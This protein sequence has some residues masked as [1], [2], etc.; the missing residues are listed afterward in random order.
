M[1]K[2]TSTSIDHYGKEYVLLVCRFCCLDHRPCTSDACWATGRMMKT[3]GRLAKKQSRKSGAYRTVGPSRKQREKLC[4]TL[5]VLGD[6]GTERNSGPPPP[7]KALSTTCCNAASNAA[8]GKRLHAA[9]WEARPNIFFILIIHLS[10]PHCYYCIPFPFFHNVQ[11]HPATHAPRAGYNREA[12]VR[13]RRRAEG[14]AA[15]ATRGE[16]LLL[17][18]FNYDS[19]ITGHHSPP[20]FC[21]FSLLVFKVRL[22]ASSS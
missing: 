22:L 7:R 14:E 6:L 8:A 16:P 10:A 21:F 13:V 15:G 2:S 4:S 19:K 20:V 1:N 11:D 9:K 5:S 18:S 17:S 3:G 12:S